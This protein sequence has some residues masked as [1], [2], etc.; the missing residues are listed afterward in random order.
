MATVGS[1][2]AGRS[3]R[4]DAPASLSGSF[5]LAWRLQWPVIVGWSLGGVACGLLAGG[6]SK[7][8]EQL[9]TANPIVAQTLQALSP[10]QKDA[11]TSTTVWAVFAFA[12]VL[13]AACAMQTVVRM[14]QEENPLR[15]A[16]HLRRTGRIRGC[17]RDC[18][19]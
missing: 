17:R 6:L 3:A 13:A 1:L 8:V 14:R 2:L 11:L 18:D 7:V 19:R 4:P 5:G 15:R 12:G 16:T 10:G 9:T